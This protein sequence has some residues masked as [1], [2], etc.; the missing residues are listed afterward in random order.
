MRAIDVITNGSDKAANWSDK[1]DWIEFTKAGTKRIVPP[2]GATRVLISATA[3]FGVYWNSAAGAPEW[4]SADV[5]DGTAPEINP[6]CRMLN[7]ITHFD[8]V[9]PGAASVSLAFYE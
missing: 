1:V 2:A 7:D 6:V 3:C 5:A 8:V 9:T 4:P